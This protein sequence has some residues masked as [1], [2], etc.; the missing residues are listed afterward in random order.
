M[1]A[2]AMRSTTATSIA[3][4]PRSSWFSRTASIARVCSSGTTGPIPPLWLRSS[5]TPK[6]STAES[7]TVA[8]RLA[9]TPV[10]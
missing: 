8:V 9:P 2:S 6:A 1:S 4:P 5:R 3:A 7:G 10:V